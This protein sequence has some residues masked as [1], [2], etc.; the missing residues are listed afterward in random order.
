MKRVARL[1]IYTG[2]ADGVDNVLSRSM[3]DGTRDGGK[4]VEIRAVEIL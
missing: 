4:G 2:P 1:I 3:P